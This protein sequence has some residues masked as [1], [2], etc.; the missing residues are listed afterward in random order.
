MELLSIIIVAISL[1]MDAFSLAL[2]YGTL[3]LGTKMLFKISLS[4]GLFHFFMP[5]LGMGIKYYLVQYSGMNLHFL[6]SI[7]YFYLGIM[8]FLEAKEE[9]KVSTLYTIKDIFLFSLAVSL[10]SL[11]VGIAQENLT[12]IAPICFA[13]SSFIFT[14]V[15]L[16]LKKRLHYLF[17]KAAIMMGG[18]F[19]ILLGLFHL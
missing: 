8:L 1:S 6:A 16:K 3:G 18:L 11:S 13:I 9:K 17:G 5:L 7:I 15:G 14:T 4:V 12:L 19:F 10:D 2:A